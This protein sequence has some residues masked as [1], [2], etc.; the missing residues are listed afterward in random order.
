MFSTHISFKESGLPPFVVGIYSFGNFHECRGIERMFS[1]K[2][3]N[4][5]NGLFNSIRRSY[6]DGFHALNADRICTSTH[7]G[8]GFWTVNAPTSCKT[9]LLPG[10][11]TMLLSKMGKSQLFDSFLASFLPKVSQTGFFDSCRRALPPKIAFIAKRSGAYLSTM[12]SSEFLAQVVGIALFLCAQYCTSFRGMFWARFATFQDT[13]FF[14]HFRRA[15][16]T[17][18]RT[19]NLRNIKEWLQ[20]VNP[21][22]FTCGQH[23]RD[24]YQ[25]KY[26]KNKS[27]FCVLIPSTL[28]FLI[29]MGIVTQVLAMIYPASVQID[30]TTNVELAC[31]RTGDAIN[32][33]SGGGS[34]GH[35]NCLSL[36][37][38]L[39]CCQGVRRHLFAQGNYSYAR[40]HPDYTFFLP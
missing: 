3:A 6:N 11:W 29:V 12:F 2:L 30:R 8:A 26:L 20:F 18:A 39:S 13:Q 10:F 9:H 37:A 1:T 32:A 35:A 33:R 21:I 16:Y 22:L 17:Q 14:A 24:K 28:Q 31:N 34:R 38:L 19:C 4:S 5:G 25:F 40:Q 23:L 36:V 7:L 27:S 15:L